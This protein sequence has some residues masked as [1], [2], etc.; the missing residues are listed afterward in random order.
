MRAIKLFNEAARGLRTAVR[1]QLPLELAL[2]EAALGVDSDATS[3]PA[4]PAATAPQ[5]PTSTPETARPQPASKRETASSAATPDLPPQLTTTAQPTTLA[6]PKP[7]YTHSA[8]PKRHAVAEPTPAPTPPP[9]ATATPAALTLDWVRGN[10]RQVGYK[11]RAL[12]PQLEGLLNSS[13]PLEVHGNVVRLGCV[14]KL[15]CDKLSDPKRRRQVEDILTDV[16]GQQTLIE[17]VVCASTA[18]GAA[19]TNNEP[20]PATCSR[21]LRGST[22]PRI[23]S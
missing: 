10:W 13:E 6:E 11:V 16:L 1:P 15:V 8:K 4:A 3:A 17:C 5:T 21:P 22:R 23:S 2:V 9:T 7:T 20:P 18:L 14:G 12:N 19:S